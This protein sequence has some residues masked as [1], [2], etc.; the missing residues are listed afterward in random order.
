LT[1][2][3]PTSLHL[4]GYLFF[5][6][7]D[8][9]FNASEEEM[10]VVIQ[11]FRKWDPGSDDKSS[12]LLY[13]S[14]E[15]YHNARTNDQIHQPINEYQALFDQFSESEKISILTSLREIAIAD[16]EINEAEENFIT[17]IKGLLEIES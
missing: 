14:F 4:L 17:A 12:P 16:G 6:L 3:N 2:S 7:A 8:I 1:P 5:A 15:W 9:D 11:Q 13:E 10:E